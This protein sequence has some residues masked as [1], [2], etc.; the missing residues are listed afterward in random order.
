MHCATD[1]VGVPARS[2]L[3]SMFSAS[4][5]L[6]CPCPLLSSYLRWHLEGIQAD[7][8]T[9]V[10]IRMVDGSNKPHFRGLE[11]VSTEEGGRRKVG[12]RIPVSNSVMTLQS[13]DPLYCLKE[14]S[15]KKSMSRKKLIYCTQQSPV[16]NQQFELKDS[17]LI[18]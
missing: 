10:Y 18:G 9:G 6:P 8:P 4:P 1:G 16:R 14:T 11:G 7:P 13:V 2:R 5:V 17:F 12:E 3:V 15:R